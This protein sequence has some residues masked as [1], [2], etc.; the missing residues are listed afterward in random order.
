MISINRQ[1]I[2]VNME[3]L[4]FE[5]LNFEILNST[6]PLSKTH[7][8]EFGQSIAVKVT[9]RVNRAKII[10]LHALITALPSVC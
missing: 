2:K 3:C 9:V 10:R 7:G 8:Y 5:T 1:I 4:K 6:A